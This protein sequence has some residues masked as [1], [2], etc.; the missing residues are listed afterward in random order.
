MAN[1]IQVLPPVNP[2]RFA[3]LQGFAQ[4]LVGG[5]NQQFQR[6]SQAQELA[7]LAQQ[8]QGGGQIDPTAFTSPEV[9]RLALNAIQQQRSRQQPILAGPGQGLID[10]QTGQL[11]GGGIPATPQRPIAVS[12]GQELFD[13][14]GRRLA[15]GPPLQRAPVALSPGQKL[16]DP[17]TGEQIALVEPDTLTVDE[18]KRADLIK[19]GLSAKAISTLETRQIKSIIAKNRAE[20][21]KLLRES[22]GVLTPE[23]T[24][25]QSNTFR[26]EFDALSNDFRK[27]RDSFQ[28]INAAAAD[29]SAAGDLAIIFNFMKILDPGS[30]VRESEFATAENAAGVPD[31]IRNMW[32]KAL[33]GERISFNRQDFVNQSRN[34]FRTQQNTQNK[35]IKRY[36]GL[37][38]RF[39]VNPQDVITETD[40]EAGVPLG[41]QGAAIRPQ[42][43][44]QVGQTV[45]NNGVEM[46]IT[47]FDTDGTPLGEPVR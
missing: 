21:E 4:N 5:L 10:P 28:R 31:K 14:S 41:G 47:G 44:F 9:A 26:K 13:V 35:L 29:P 11:V 27:I 3:G 15:Q 37:A 36:T 23:Q 45:L 12:P 20:S 43:Q 7:A 1:G 24:I 32:N 33:T 38:E 18:R 40:I 8:L 19:A 34:L 30:V 2:N 22:K 16:V 25:S 46:K 17:D 6:R 39:G 42:Q